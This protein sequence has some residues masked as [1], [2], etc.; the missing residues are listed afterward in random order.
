[1]DAR[2]VVRHLLLDRSARRA[3]E[4]IP[5]PQSLRIAC[6]VNGETVQDATTA[7]MIFPVAQLVAFVSEAITLEPGDLLATGTPPGVA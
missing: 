5:D 4:E 3:R 1:V 7:D 2:E 6:R